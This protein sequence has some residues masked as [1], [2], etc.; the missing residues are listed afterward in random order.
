MRKWLL[1]FFLLVCIP[2][3]LL[4]YVCALPY[5]GDGLAILTIVNQSEETV[6]LLQVKIY[7]EIQTVKDLEHGEEAEMQFIVKR[8]T[9]YHVNV[10]FLSGRKI[11]KEMGYLT[12]GFDTRDKITIYKSDIEYT[13]RTVE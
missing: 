6:V 2:I 1:R 11:I 5:L 10:E 9:D 12:S 7:E 8:D 13:T 4:L 3:I